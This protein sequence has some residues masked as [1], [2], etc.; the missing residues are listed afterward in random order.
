MVEAK[1]IYLKT[2][3]KL[4]EPSFVEVKCDLTCFD[5]IAVKEEP[6]KVEPKEESEH[7]E[8][9]SSDNDESQDAEEFISTDAH[10]MD[11]D[12][13]EECKTEEG[14]AVTA[15]S[16][17]ESSTNYK[18]SSKFDHVMADYIDVTCHVCG[19][20]FQSLSEAKS[21]LRNKHKVRSLQLKCCQRKVILHEIDRHILSHS[22][23]E[24]YR[25]DYCSKFFFVKSKLGSHLRSHKP[26]RY[27]CDICKKRFVDMDHVRT[28]ILGSHCPKP[29]E[30]P[31]ECTVCNKR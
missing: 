12:P 26:K 2:H 8:S 23:P 1:D 4:D 7:S 22:N 13:D 25:C 30:R 19:H 20:P 14:E 28:H 27:E 10:F 5:G 16:P 18:K 9:N 24:I 15:T 21:H 6:T 29:T 31:H 3:V 17:S 11:V